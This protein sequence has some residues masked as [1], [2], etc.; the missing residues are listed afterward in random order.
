MT[1]AGNIEICKSCGF[2]GVENYCGR[3][4]RPYKTKRISLTGLLH[5]IFHLFTHLDKGFGYTLKLLVLS[6]GHMQRVFIEGERNRYQKPFSMFFICATLAALSR[7]WIFK[8]LHT[9]YHTDSISEANFFHEYMVLLQIALLPLNAFITCLFFYRS[10]YNYAEIG[11]LVL[12][13]MAFLFVISIIIMLLKFFWP[14]LDTA[15]IELPIMII[16]S[17]ITN[18]NFFRGSNP[19]KVALKSLVIITGLFFLIQVAE[20]FVK[21]IIS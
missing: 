10:K 21:N 3:C 2:S 9:Y 13:T 11:V 14:D 19:W 16:Y 8:A 4:G 12:Y 6:P 18:I 7:Y 1:D 15:Y 20:D 17:I 5:D